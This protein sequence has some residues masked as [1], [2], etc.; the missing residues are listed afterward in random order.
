MVQKKI[1]NSPMVWQNLN[2]SIYKN[3]PLK[4]K[5]IKIYHEDGSIIHSG[6]CQFDNGSMLRIEEIIKNR[7]GNNITDDQPESTDIVIEP[8]IEKIDFDNMPPPSKLY[9]GLIEIIPKLYLGNIYTV[10]E[11][12]YLKSH[13]INYILNVTLDVD[14]FFPT[15]FSYHN[16]A[17]K[18]SEHSNIHQYFNEANHFIE[19]SLNRNDGSVLVHCKGGVSRSPTI[20]MAYLIYRYK[21]PFK[22]ALYYMQSRKSGVNPNDGFISQLM[23]YEKL[24][25]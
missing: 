24:V 4:K 10:K 20:I 5:K 16:I 25:I 22:K 13:S 3:F 19:R 18:D 11:K 14:N 2:A 15:D 1:I 7:K 9:H 8:E 23:S 6:F 21:L 12:D 17:V